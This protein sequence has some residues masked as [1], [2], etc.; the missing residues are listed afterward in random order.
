MRATG[1]QPTL[2]STTGRRVEVGSFGIQIDQTLFDGFQTRNN[3]RSAEANVRASQQ[4]LRNTEQN[5]LLDA[6]TAYMDVI[7]D[8]QIAVLTRAESCVPERTGARGPVALRCRR[9]YPDRRRPGRGEPRQRHRHPDDAKA[10]ALRSAAIYRQ[11]I[12]E[13]PGKL[14]RRER[15][16][17]G[18]CRNR[19]TGAQSIAAEEHPAI[20]ATEHLVDAAGFTVKSAEGQLLPQLRRVGRCDARV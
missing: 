17:Q 9:G 10:R 19:S 12:G 14:K 3:V 13:E 7:R 4:S 5:I 6:A 11:V 20:I 16:C 18:C 1:F 2:D 15:R 8:R